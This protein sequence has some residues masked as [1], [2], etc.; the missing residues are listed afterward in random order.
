[1]SDV[2]VEEKVRVMLEGDQ[3]TAAL[4]I[5]DR[6]VYG[7]GKTEEEARADLCITI[8][9]LVAEGR[10]IDPLN[11]PVAVRKAVL[12]YGGKVADMARSELIKKTAAYLYF[13]PGIG[14]P[15]EADDPTTYVLSPLEV[16]ANCIHRGAD[17]ANTDP[18]LMPEVVTWF[19]SEITALELS[20]EAAKR[21][22]FTEGAQR[23]Q[24]KAL[25]LREKLAFCGWGWGAF[26]RAT[27]DHNG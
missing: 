7:G 18:A 19:R 2:K 20:A 27:S 13:A 23:A 8:Y 5:G 22:G 1:M 25:A 9:G 10:N 17:L 11:L 15:P 4:W 14:Y 16:A 26:G 21:K 6:Y 3:Y 24:A 12:E